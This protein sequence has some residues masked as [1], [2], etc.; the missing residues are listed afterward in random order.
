MNPTK[1]VITL[2]FGN[3]VD[4]H[5]GMEQIGKMVKK[6][7]RFNYSNN[8]VFSR[9]ETSGLDIMEIVKEEK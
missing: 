5:V 7:E 1:S 9:F 6:E 2:T 3:Q 4:N 8:L